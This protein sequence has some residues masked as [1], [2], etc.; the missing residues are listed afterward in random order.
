MRAEKCR[1]DFSA[2]FPVLAGKEV[3]ILKKFSARDLGFY[4]LVLLLKKQNSTLF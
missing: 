4:M 3:M 2:L 1:R